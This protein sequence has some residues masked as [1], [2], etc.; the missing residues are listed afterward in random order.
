MARHDLVNLLFINH[1]NQPFTATNVVADPAVWKPIDHGTIIDHVSTE[2][3]FVLL[4]LETN[5]ASGM[6]RHVENSKLSVP[7]VDNITWRRRN[8][9]KC[10]MWE[11]DIVTALQH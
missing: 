7:K 6:A 4:V 5:A 1:L 10:G 3:H 2:Q 11:L 8:I 9:R